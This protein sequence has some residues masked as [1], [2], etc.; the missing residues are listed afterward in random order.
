MGVID[1]LV[2]VCYLGYYV[3]NSGCGL[4][5]SFLE[6]YLD[7]QVQPR[8]QECCLSV[9]GS[10]IWNRVYSGNVVDGVEG[11]RDLERMGFACCE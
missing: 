11:V 2:M 4:R 9:D 8:R 6:S 7:E 5:A 3:P 10:V 1:N